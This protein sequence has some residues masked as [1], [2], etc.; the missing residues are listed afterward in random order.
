MQ[1]NLRVKLEISGL[2]LM[3]VGNL[4]VYQGIDLLLESFALVLKLAE[5]DLVIIGGENSDI[6][7]YQKKINV[8]MREY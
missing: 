5:V 1:E 6:Q 7:K 4:Q 2:L 8:Q 3:Y